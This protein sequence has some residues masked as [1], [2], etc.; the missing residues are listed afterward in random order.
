M[1][2]KKSKVKT[3]QAVPCCRFFNSL[4]LILIIALWRLYTHHGAIAYQMHYYYSNLIKMPNGS[5]TISDLN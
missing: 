5:N 1:S 3:V 4:F 2:K